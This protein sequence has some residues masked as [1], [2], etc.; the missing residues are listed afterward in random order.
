[1]IAARVA[2]G[3][4]VALAAGSRASGRRQAAVTARMTAAVYSTSGRRSR[5]DVIVADMSGFLDVIVG[6]PPCIW[7]N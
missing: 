2:N 5:G 1:M 4:A 6:V 3:P 7:Q